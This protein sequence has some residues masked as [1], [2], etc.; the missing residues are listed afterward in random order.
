MTS[1][2]DRIQKF[3]DLLERAR[4][5]QKSLGPLRPLEGPFLSDEDGDRA[6][7][8]AAKRAEA[9]LTA[10]KTNPSDLDSATYDLFDFAQLVA[11]KVPPTIA[12]CK[13]PLA[14]GDL[15]FSSIAGLSETKEIFRAN[16]I[17]PFI[18]PSLFPKPAKGVLLYGSPGTG[19][20]L[21]ARAAS[22]EIPGLAFFAPSPGDLRSMYEGGTEKAIKLV[23]DCADQYVRTTPG[24][25]IAIIFFDEFDSIA[26]KRGDDRSMR[27]S[28]NALLQAMDGVSASPRVSVIAAT[29]YPSSL[30]DAIMRRF[31][32]SIFVDLPD[33]EAIEYLIRDA[34]AAAYNSPGNR[35]PALPMGNAAG[36]IVQ[37][38]YL[39][40]IER[41]GLEYVAKNGD[42]NPV[43]DQYILDLVPRFGPTSA[44]RDIINKLR[45]NPASVSDDDSRLDSP[46][47]IFG[48]SPS[49]ITKIMQLAVTY[50][51]TRAVGHDAVFQEVVRG[52]GGW[53]IHT[54][55][56][57]VEGATAILDLEKPE[58]R[59]K[60]LNFDI[61]RSDVERAM[62]SYA[63][64]VDNHRYVEVL[65]HSLTA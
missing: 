1:L 52:D 3:N 16:Y 43:T 8:D 11:N 53:W 9:L 6:I 62:K 20:T 27:L 55:Y 32:Q 51:S 49:D 2:R 65:K 18:F 38:D 4:S 24:V 48:Y 5:R 35:P 31:T 50:A 29:N 40:N 19:K 21:L 25:E 44:G 15:N 47:H 23:F 56:E 13:P 63:S 14:P 12:E 54:P 17:N 64:T 22:A 61:R 34:L 46:V 41:M 59:R 39:E 45:K 10:A 58:D 37:G 57:E 42:E 28:V 33:S 26:G 36:M 7:I 30:D 60:V